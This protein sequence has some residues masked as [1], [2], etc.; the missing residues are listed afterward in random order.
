MKHMMRMPK[1]AMKPA[2]DPLGTRAMAPQGAGMGAGM[3]SSNPDM[4]EQQTGAIGPMSMAP[5]RLG[6]L[7]NLRMMMQKRG[8]RY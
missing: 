3:Q 4:R 5:P 6:S 1:R 2:P 8:M 7:K